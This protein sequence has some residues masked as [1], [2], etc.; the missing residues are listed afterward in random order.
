MIINLKIIIIK[1]YYEE[2][3]SNFL[4]DLFKDKR[5]A[6]VFGYMVTFKFY[7]DFIVTPYPYHI[8]LKNDDTHLIILLYIG[9]NFK[10]YMEMD[11][12]HIVSFTPIVWEMIEYDHLDVKYV[13]KMGL[14]HMITEL[15]NETRA[16]EIRF[17]LY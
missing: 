2:P 9:F 13:S 1:I 11:S 6:V 12:V 14:F 15:V 4:L 7:E 17:L 16:E 5:F 8:E 10:K 3:G